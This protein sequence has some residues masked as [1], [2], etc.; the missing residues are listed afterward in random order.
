MFLCI[1]L[2]GI[3]Y[4]HRYDHLSKVLTKILDERPAD[5]VDIIEN[6]S[7]DVKMANFNQKLDMLHNEN[8]MLP[9]YEIAETQKALFLQGH[10]EGADSELEEEIVS[11][12]QLSRYY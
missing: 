5:A 9:A 12:Y 1:L 8:E 3:F 10:L 6:I 2:S 7:Q 4:L 11:D